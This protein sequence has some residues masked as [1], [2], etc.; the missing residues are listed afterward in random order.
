MLDW[1]KERIRTNLDN[2]ISA[3]F[4]KENDLLIGVYKSY[5]YGQENIYEQNLERKIPQKEIFD[6]L[7]TQCYLWEYFLGDFLPKK[8][9]R[10][11]FETIDL[12]GPL[13]IAKG[14]SGKLEAKNIGKNVLREDEL[15]SR[16]TSVYNSVSP[17]F[18]MYSEE[19]FLNNFI[20]YQ[21]FKDNFKPYEC[22]CCYYDELNDCSH[23]WIQRQSEY[24]LETVTNHEIAHAISQKVN[25]EINDSYLAEVHSIYMSLYTDKK[26]YEQTNDKKYLMSSKNYLIFLQNTVSFLAILN[27]ISECKTLNYKNIEKALGSLNIYAHDIKTYIQGFINA[28]VSVKMVY[29]LSSIASLHLLLLDEEKANSLFSKSVLNEF[30]S[31]HKFF[32]NIE[33]NL[34]DQTS[35]TLTYNQAICD[36][37][38]IIRVRK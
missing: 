4:A 20:K 22:S 28:N 1:N 27:K 18:K 14:F 32:K 35:A 31:Y 2:I 12:L 13:F 7:E 38:Q 3:G 5:L 24:A 21:A 23:I 29:F 26:L 30:S 25:Y 37:E 10:N 9:A 15:F 11:V 8:L 6:K 16:S 17:L 36:N 34:N 19:L 33:F